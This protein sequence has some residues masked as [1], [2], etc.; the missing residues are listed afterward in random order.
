VIPSDQFASSLTKARRAA[1]GG[2][3]KPETPA[4]VLYTSGTTGRPKGCVLSHG[5]EVASGARYAS[6]GGLAV[7]RPG[8]DRIYKPLPLYH[9]NSGVFSLFGAIV[10]GNRFSPNASIP[11][12]GGARSPDKGDCRALPRHHCC[13]AL[14]Q[15]PDAHERS[16]TVRFGI[17][18]GVEPQLHRAIEQRFGFPL[19]EV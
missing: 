17:G 18:A 6:L 14:S 5:Y 19:I 12:A 15:P 1:G 3:P 9:A 13:N 4:S 10:T 2:D 7:L 11:S 16:H 8:Q